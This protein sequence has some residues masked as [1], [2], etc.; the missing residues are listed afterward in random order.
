M[1]KFQSLIA[2]ILCIVCLSG[3][4]TSKKMDA[5]VA[6]EYG[7]QLP[8]QNKKTK[9]DITVNSVFHRD[10][11]IS[12][13]VQKTSHLLPLIVYFQYDYRHTCTLNPEIAVTE[14]A[15]TVHAQ[16][17]KL[18]QKLNEQRLEL[19]VE[20]VPSAFALVDKA[21]LL[22]FLIS[23]DKIYVE[24]DFKD[25]VVAYK[26][27]QN[28]NVVKTGKLVVKNNERNKG[29]RFF[30]SWKS[31]TREYLSDY[32]ADVTAMSKSAINQLLALL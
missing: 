23:W 30:Q 28:N 18:L 16:S 4:L 7:N 8:R 19:T 12:T 20:Q 17:D 5:Y 6:N 9:A 14:F 21:H 24:P 15:N 25:L 31:S 27:F 10:K 11:S 1:Q 22:L 2:L 13:T 26:L 3:C 32:N 29:I